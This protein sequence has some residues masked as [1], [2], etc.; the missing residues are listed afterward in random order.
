M[1]WV[2]NPTLAPILNVCPINDVGRSLLPLPPAPSPYPRPCPPGMSK[3]LLCLYT[4]QLAERLRDKGVMVNAVCPGWVGVKV[5]VPGRA[6]AGTGN[7]R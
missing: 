6:G 4:A 7:S 3:L 2:L 5:R 1:L